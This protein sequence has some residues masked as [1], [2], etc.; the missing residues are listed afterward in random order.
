[1]LMPVRSYFRF[2]SNSLTRHAHKLL[3]E[4]ALSHF[5]NLSP[6]LLETTPK[7]PKFNFN[8]ILR[9]TGLVSD[10]ELQFLL[11]RHINVCVLKHFFTV[12]YTK[13]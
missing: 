4:L 5:I 1:M 2:L 13:S 11:Y 10:S 8:H 6:T 7:T 12:S 9:I 3:R